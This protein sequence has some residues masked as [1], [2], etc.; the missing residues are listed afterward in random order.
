MP[1][2]DYLSR[3]TPSDLHLDGNPGTDRPLFVQFCANQPDVLLNAARYVAP[4]CDAVDLNLGCPQGIA[5]KGKY[6]AFLQ[7]DWDL[8]YKIINTLHQNLDVPVTA[9][10]RILETKER[11]LDYA[12]MILS[13]G[14]SIITVHGRRRDQKGH[15]TGL[16]DWSYIRYLREH[17]PSETVIF[18]NGNIL[19][20]NDLDRCL[21]ETGADAV[22][23]AEGNL[24]DPAIFTP[25]LHSMTDEGEKWIGKD[26]K[27]GLR[28]DAVMRRYLDIIYRHV[29]GVEPPTRPPLALASDVTTI[30]GEPNQE[31]AEEETRND[32][33]ANGEPPKKKQ[34]REKMEREKRKRSGKREVDPSICAMRAHLFSLLYPL[35]SRHTDVRDCL[36]RTPIGDMAGFEEVLQ[37]V[38]AKTAQGLRDYETEQ[39]TVLATGKPPQ[40]QEDNASLDG[41]Q[42]ESS[43]AAIERCRRPWWVC[44]PH[45]RP[46]P[47]EALQKGSMTLSKKAKKKLEQEEALK[48]ESAIAPEGHVE[49]VPTNVGAEKVELPREGLVCG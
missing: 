45:I 1:S 13:A 44:Q 5:R 37:M 47:H 32:G 24:H 8:I 19:Q 39:S 25:P 7:E 9:K 27:G 4:F 3:L 21:Q 22:M 26:G 14:A 15:Q 34:K 29:L 41:D 6:G 38:E 31:R 20:H 36:A 17:L 35:I 33:E 16:A 11:T 49:A 2:D 42:G 23:S 18:A 48:K 28:M 10:I 30:M 43:A 46:L 40:D 12:K